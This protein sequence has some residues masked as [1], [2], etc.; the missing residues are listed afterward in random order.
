MNDCEKY[1][2]LPMVGGKPKANTFRESQER[3][4]IGV[5]GWKEKFISK[6]SWEILIKTIAQA[7]PAYSMNLFKL[8]KSFCDNINSILARY[9]WGQKKEEG[10]LHWINWQK[11]CKGKAKGG[12]GF[13][14]INA[15]NLAM[16][17]KRAWQLPLHAFSVLQNL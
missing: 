3:I 5:L 15:F 8:P 10:K 12:M 16:L 1:L 14:D 13:R 17:A 11:L 7:I 2:D 6:A 9:W 4:S